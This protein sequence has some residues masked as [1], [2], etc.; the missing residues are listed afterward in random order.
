L[1]KRLLQRVVQTHLVEPK[2]A[3]RRED[4]VFL[5]DDPDFSDAGME[6]AIARATLLL[7]D[8]GSQ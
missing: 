8:V 4:V 3:R 5:R 7:R 1:A 2:G 6:Y